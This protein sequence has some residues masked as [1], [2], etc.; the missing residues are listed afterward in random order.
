MDDD[1]LGLDQQ[2]EGDY[3]D[4]TANPLAA[5][6]L[7]AGLADGAFESKSEAN[8]TTGEQAASAK[9]E[10]GVPAPQEWFQAGLWAR[11][12]EPLVVW[13]TRATTVSGSVG[14][15]VMVWS[16]W[17]VDLNYVF[18]AVSMLT[19]VQGFAFALESLRDLVRPQ[20][21]ALAAL[22]RAAG[23]EGDG[24]AIT[25]TAD[26]LDSLVRWRRGVYGFAGVW[27]CL[28]GSVMLAELTSGKPLKDIVHAMS[29]LL[30][31]FSVGPVFAG[32]YMSLRL[33]CALANERVAQLT[34]A[35]SN[36]ATATMTTAEWDT[37]IRDPAVELAEVTMPALSRWGAPAAAIGGGFGVFALG[38]L[39]W[40]LMSG[41]SPAFVL[42]FLLI[43]AVFAVVLVPAGVSTKCELLIGTLNQLRK[44]ADRRIQGHI[45]QLES[46]LTSC[47]REQGIGFQVFSAVI[48]RQQLKVLFAKT[49][50]ILVAMYLWLG[51]LMRPA[52][53]D[54]AELDTGPICGNLGWYHAEGSC[55]RIFG[56]VEKS[57][58]KTWPEAE[59]HCQEF[60]GNL[61]RIS[62]AAQHDATQVLAGGLTAIWIGLSD[63]VDEGNFVWSDG[64]PVEFTQW[65]TGEP[66]DL[67]GADPWPS[68][69]EA[70]TPEGCEGSED[71]G[72]LFY[73]GGRYSW[74][75]TNCEVKR[76]YF[77]SVDDNRI[78]IWKTGPNGACVEFRLPYIC[79]KPSI[80]AAAHGGL[81]H[82][83]KN[84]AWMLGTAHNN[85]DL[86]PTIVRL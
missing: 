59:I 55:Y 10:N 9:K 71:C 48:N 29:M 67:A 78:N 36:P 82:G 32:W 46:F 18:F 8:A 47:N 42:S 30:W 86:P 60:G 68:D 64:Q 20:T 21:G 58:W 57:E 51:P 69:S 50:A 33:A 84:G 39:N 79:S 15:G 4:T 43:G 52:L 25:I 17:D 14:A 22:A 85:P 53:P 73:V 49:W 12:D 7:G 19:C 66:G 34:H 2:G 54:L 5:V 35:V 16:V 74:G 75:D 13:L 6:G 80:P 11:L 70:G 63:R 56:D 77:Q 37:A 81:M 83:C 27:C 41:D 38:V 3:D 61:A 31:L 72:A 76:Q 40:A 62:N 45:S 26:A 44:S 65:K 28:L 23:E 24:A 1:D